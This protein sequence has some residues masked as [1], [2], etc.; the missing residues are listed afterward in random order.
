M[1]AFD[2]QVGGGHYKDMAI[3]PVEFIMANDLPFCEANVVKY[4]CR[5]KQKGGIQDLHKVI[6]YVELLIE[7]EERNK[8]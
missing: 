8:K 4:I 5:W 3:Q 2:K 6:H 1:S 7:R